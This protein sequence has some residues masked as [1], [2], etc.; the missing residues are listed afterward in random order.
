MRLT[1]RFFAF[2]MMIA[3]FPLMG[4]KSEFE[5]VR[6]SPDPKFVFKKAEEYYDKKEYNR[7]RI[8]YELVTAS[9]NG[10]PEAESIYF[11]YAYCHYYLGE[12]IS[13]NYYFRQFANT[14]PNSKFRE[15]ADFMG[16]Y[17]NYQMSPGYK[18]DQTNTEKAIEGFQLFVNTYPESSRVAETNKLI[19]ELRRKQEKKA[20]EEGELYYNLKYY[21]A[22]VRTFENLLK[23][24][25]ETP[26][27]EK[28]RHRIVLSYYEW[29]TN[30]IFE[31]K[32]ERYEASKT[33][34]QDFMT[35][36]PGSNFYKEVNAILI[37][38]NKR[39]KELSK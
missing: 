15:E 22:A 27:A 34:A 26:D 35:R 24:F 2:L 12:Y 33:A 31:K 16:A 36:Y 10:Q 11:K 19:D 25:A 3:L 17:S 21:Q 28:I 14:F 13:S 23:D 39:L 1:I 32:T 7:A 8:L 29:A 37:T 38:S 18:L 30:S 9:F 20:Y 6:V 4:C 5:R